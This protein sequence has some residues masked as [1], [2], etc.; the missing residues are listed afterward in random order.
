MYANAT[1]KNKS[2]ILSLL[3]KILS[4]SK[5]KDFGFCF[6]I[7]PSQLSIN[8][9]I[10]QL[11]SEFLYNNLQKLSI[12]KQKQ[13]S[14]IN[15]VYFLEKSKYNIYFELKSQYPDIKLSLSSFYKLYLKNFKKAQKKTDIC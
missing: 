7:P 8:K 3:A 5:I 6:I 14:E 4:R 13:N 12:T 2:N 11:I 15:E 9:S 10:K 1:L